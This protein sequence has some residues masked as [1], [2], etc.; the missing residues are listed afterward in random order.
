M[1][2]IFSWA[3]ISELNLKHR[4]DLSKIIFGKRTP[5]IIKV[6]KWLILSFGQWPACPNKKKNELDLYT[7]AL[8]SEQNCVR[9][10]INPSRIARKCRKIISEA[11]FLKDQFNFQ[12]SKFESFQRIFR[13]STEAWNDTLTKKNYNSE[14]SSPHCDM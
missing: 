12:F 4:Q 13:E 11:A 3:L 2:T 1:W 10:S 14:N 9:P 6:T 5:D 8:Q 7:D